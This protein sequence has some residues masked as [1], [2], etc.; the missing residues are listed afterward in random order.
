MSEADLMRLLQRRASQLG[1]RLFR[2]NVGQAWTG[3]LER[4]NGRVVRLGPGDVVLRNARPFHAGVSGMSD[5]G[6][7]L[8]V[9]VTPDMVGSTI[10]IY[11]QVEVKAGGRPTSEQLAWIAAVNK[12]G[13]R[14]GV[15]HNEA[16]LSEIINGL[17]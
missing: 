9:Q 8:P 6:G 3:M 16:E 12:A 14:A 4:G 17:L 2:Q 7:W 11:V 1:A 5:L 10:A 13:G 15:A